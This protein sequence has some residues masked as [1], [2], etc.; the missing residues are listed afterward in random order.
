MDR[1]RAEHSENKIQHDVILNG[2]KGR[3]VQIRRSRGTW[4]HCYLDM[5]D[6]I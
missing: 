4:Q 3:R 1:S 6:I 5:N 2:Y